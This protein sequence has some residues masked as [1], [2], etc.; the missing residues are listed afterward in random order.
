MKCLFALAM[1]IASTGTCVA[2]PQFCEI[3]LN[4]SLGRIAAPRAHFLTGRDGCPSD[5]PRCVLK[6]YLV[7]D[8]VVLLGKKTGAWQCALFIRDGG[9][10]GFLPVTALQVLP[11]TANPPPAAWAGHWVR[12]K[13]ASVD[14]KR[15]GAALSV[16]GSALWHGGPE[17]VHDGELGGEASPQGDTLLLDGR[18]T[19]K[20]T[21]MCIAMLTLAGQ[22][23]DG[24]D[25]GSCG[26]MNVSFD[27]EY[28]RR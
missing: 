10:D 11:S 20:D 5:A 25:N 6:S 23:L 14:I 2:E 21:Y 27:G 4:P 17:N 13:D 9:T 8:D 24:E 28:R 15:Q 16:D 26:G 22:A 1:L 19:P 7:H 3:P 12:D 18:E